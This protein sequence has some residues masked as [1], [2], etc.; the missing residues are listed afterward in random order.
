M[1]FFPGPG[2]SIGGM[3]DICIL[4]GGIFSAGYP[5]FVG[6]NIGMIKKTFGKIGACR[7]GLPCFQVPALINVRPETERF[8]YLIAG[9]YSS[10]SM[11][12]YPGL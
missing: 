8:E 7:N 6:K 12:Q 2:Y 5:Y 11:A 3:P 10:F 9:N 4:C 1:V